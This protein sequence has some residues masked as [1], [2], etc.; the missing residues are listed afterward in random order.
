MK[1]LGDSFLCEEDHFLCEED[2]LPI[3]VHQGK[4]RWLGR[5]W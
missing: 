2:R 3:I 5:D 4:E 1:F